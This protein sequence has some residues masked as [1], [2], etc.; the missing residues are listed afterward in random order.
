MATD[1]TLDELARRGQLEFAGSGS[2]YVGG[3][4]NDAFAEAFEPLVEKLVPPHQ[5]IPA[6]LPEAAKRSSVLT[7]A[8]RL[9]KGGDPLSI[10]IVYLH[11]WVLDAVDPRNE[12]DRR[13]VEALAAV[14]AA[15]AGI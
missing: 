13:A 5:P 10:E 7:E 8:R 12:G 11:E 1:D 9:A 3:A 6:M 2:L 14:M 4:R 15:A